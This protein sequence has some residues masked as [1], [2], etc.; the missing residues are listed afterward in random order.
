MGLSIG[1]SI[2]VGAGLIALGGGSAV[3][4]YKIKDYRE[5]KDK[6]NYFRVLKDMRGKR[7]TARIYSQ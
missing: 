5:K 3:A 6:E 4:Y 1:A 7:V 2:A